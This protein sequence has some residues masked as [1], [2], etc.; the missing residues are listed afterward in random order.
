VSRGAIQ[1]TAASSST[2][3]ASMPVRAP[4]QRRCATF[5]EEAW[6]RLQLEMRAPSSDPWVKLQAEMRRERPTE[7]VFDYIARTTNYRPDVRRI[8]Q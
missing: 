7:S 4:L 5:F 2:A 3:F 1:A 8:R 6:R